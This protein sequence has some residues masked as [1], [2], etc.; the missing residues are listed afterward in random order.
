MSDD[1]PQQNGE[2]IRLGDDER[3]RDFHEAF[4]DPATL[5]QLFVD[6]AGAAEVLA[7]MAK[8]GTTDRAHGGTLSLEE[9]RA[10]FMDKKVRG[11]QVRYRYEG[12][13]WWDTL[14]RTPAGVRIVRIEQEDWE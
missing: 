3:L 4:I 13:E 6:W 10:L 12:S 1:N 9:G 8:G 7:V 11:L 2:E 5:E 14:M